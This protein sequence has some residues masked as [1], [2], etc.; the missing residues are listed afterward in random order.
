[1]LSACPHC[2]GEIEITREIAG[3]LVACPYCGNQFTTATQLALPVPPYR[4]FLI[5]PQ[6]PASQPQIVVIH[7]PA[8]ASHRYTQPRLRA[9][10]W[11]SR[12]FASAFG[13]M[14]AIAVVVVG[15]PLA[16]CGGCLMID[17]QSKVHDAQRK[18]RE[19]LSKPE[20][21]RDDHR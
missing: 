11:F 19:Q 13:V 5:D 17:A 14:L 3:V 15:I 4:Q 18:A 8:P 12:S 21:E 10:G 20:V 2:Q 1:M 9:G 16:L 6:E 7:S